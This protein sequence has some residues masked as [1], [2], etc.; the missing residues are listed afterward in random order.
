MDGRRWEIDKNPSE[1]EK[2]TFAQNKK[3]KRRD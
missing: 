3:K 2:K 1:K